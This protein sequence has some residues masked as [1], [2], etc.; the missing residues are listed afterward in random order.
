MT[1]GISPIAPTDPSTSTTSFINQTHGLDVTNSLLNDTKLTLTSSN[2]VNVSNIVSMYSSDCPTSILSSGIQGSGISLVS[3][4]NGSMAPTNTSMADVEK[5]TQ[6][7]KY[8]GPSSEKPAE[9]DLVYDLSSKP[10]MV[11]LLHSQ[12]G[13]F[14]V[15]VDSSTSIPMVI[16]SFSSTYS[17]PP[18]PAPNPRSLA[19]NLQRVHQSILT[20]CTTCR[21]A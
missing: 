2:T 11:N 10:S 16:S 1:K 4:S 6:S 14:P 13:A 8:L 15:A 18:P 20:K 21:T 19:I 3:S 7:V 5:A 17:Q 12:F 9:T